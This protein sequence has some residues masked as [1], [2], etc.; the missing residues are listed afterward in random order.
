LLLACF[1]ARDAQQPILV[2][3]GQPSAGKLANAIIV[4]NDTMAQLRVRNIP[5][6]LV[7]ALRARAAK[8]G[9][10]A[11]A[12]HRLILAEVL[13]PKKPDFWMEADRLRRETP[14][15]KTNSTDLLRAMR[16]DREILKSARRKQAT[17]GRVVLLSEVAG[18]R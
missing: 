15:Q 16:D 2:E 18:S 12:E 1:A 10:S 13:R 4:Y 17:A 14:R 3:K 5:E 8:H 6:T 7:R 11:E 9:R